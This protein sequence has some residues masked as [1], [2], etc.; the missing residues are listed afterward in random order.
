[1]VYGGN[2]KVGLLLIP[3]SGLFT[4]E[5]FLVD[6]ILFMSGNVDVHPNLNEIRDHKYVSKK[7]LIAMFDDPGT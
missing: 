7:E 2:T 6:Y 4:E 3:T 1:M 5:V